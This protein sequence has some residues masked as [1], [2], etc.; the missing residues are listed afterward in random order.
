MGKRKKGKKG[1]PFMTTKK[2]AK[3]GEK[4]S[5]VGK[6]FLGGNYIYP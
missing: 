1:G 6:I 4:N 5:R 2:S 3:K